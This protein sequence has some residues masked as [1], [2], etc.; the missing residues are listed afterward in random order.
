[1]RVFSCVL[2]MFSGSFGIDCLEHLG[3]QESE[4]PWSRIQVRESSRVLCILRT[5][6]VIV[7]EEW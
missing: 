1:M 7:A 4:D 5:V 2:D 3:Y 6:S